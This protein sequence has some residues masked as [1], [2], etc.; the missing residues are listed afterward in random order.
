MFSLWLDAHLVELLVKKKKQFHN[1][2]PWLDA[3]L[4]ELQ[5]KRNN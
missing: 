4:V 2:P 1:V 3:H 5:M